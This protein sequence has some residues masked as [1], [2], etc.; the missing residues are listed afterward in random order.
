MASVRVAVPRFGSSP[1]ALNCRGS[2][3]VVIERPKTHT[4][5]APVTSLNTLMLQ[6]P[7]V[8]RVHLIITHGRLHSGTA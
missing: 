7:P 5:G 6:A 8:G 1:S 4:V 2:V 3:R